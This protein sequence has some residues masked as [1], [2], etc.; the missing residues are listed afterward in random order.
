MTAPDPTLQSVTE[1]L[2]GL[3]GR[4]EAVAHKV[5]NVTENMDKLADK[6]A[7]IAHDLERVT[8]NTNRYEQRFER[9]DGRLWT[10]SLWLVG[11]ALAAIFAA[12]GV[13]LVRS[14]AG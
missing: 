2:D 11:T 9:L 7:Q 6:F 12:V 13:V 1:K 5:D 4:I 14:L 3:A 8:E 10:L